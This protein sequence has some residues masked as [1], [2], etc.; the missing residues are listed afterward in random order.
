ME[1]WED[2]TGLTR[3]SSAAESL[4]GGGGLSILKGKVIIMNS[5]FKLNG[6]FRLNVFHVFSSFLVIASMYSL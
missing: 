5:Y 4:K 2:S 6:S 3:S 1:G